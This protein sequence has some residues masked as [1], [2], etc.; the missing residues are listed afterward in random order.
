MNRFDWPCP[1][2]GMV[3]AWWCVETEMDPQLDQGRW[4]AQ[5]LISQYRARR[6]AV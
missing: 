6:F 4:H 1:D 5:R 3:P 2:I